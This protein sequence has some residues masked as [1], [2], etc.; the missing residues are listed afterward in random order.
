MKSS[1]LKKFFKFVIPVVIIVGGWGLSK[2]IV[3]VASPNEESTVVDTVPTVKVENAVG[4][5]YQMI[6]TAH[7]EVE[8]IE[9]TQVSAKVSGEVT[10]WHENFIEGGLIQRGELLFTIEKDLYE[11]AVL[12]AE[13]AL[14]SAEAALIEEEALADVSRDEAKR[15]PNKKYTDLFLRKPQIL[16][17]KAAVK[18]AQAQLKAAKRDL[19]NAEVYAPFDALVV[20]RDIGVG[21]FLIAG[22]SVA[23]IYNIESA[24]I[25]API[26]GFDSVFLP[27]SLNG[28]PVSVFEQGLKGVERNG[29]IKHDLGVV[30]QDTRMSSLVIEVKDPYSIGSGLPALKFG[31]Y[32]AVRFAG[33]T[34]PHVYKLPQDLVNNKTVWVVNS[35]LQ[36]E[37]RTVQVIREEDK[38]FI[39]NSGLTDNDRI[40][41]TPPEYPQKGMSVKIQDSEIETPEADSQTNLSS[42]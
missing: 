13:A 40:V 35:D 42:L 7:G 5:D 25:V 9:I 1:G 17:A 33:K 18:S 8:P 19:T 27:E 4:T 21:Q 29:F 24:K 26:P 12:Q 39:I 32:V 37:P 30:D 14:I 6:L 34:L 10:S 36:L 41:T 11:A 38:Y 2:I 15:N 23:T 16:S 22:S 28:T 20:T 31:S 3:A